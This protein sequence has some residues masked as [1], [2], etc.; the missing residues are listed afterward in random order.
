M[1]L[2]FET[3]DAMKPCS[4][5]VA[6]LAMARKLAVWIYRIVMKGMDFVNN[7]LE[8]YEE[9][10]KKQKIKWIERQAKELNLMVTPC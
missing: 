5:S 10:L 9:K 7:G 3:E 2:K 8:Q 6:T 4:T 1:L